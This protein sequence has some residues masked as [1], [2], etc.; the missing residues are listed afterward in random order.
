M[1]NAA[2]IK[3][4][5]IELRTVLD[6]TDEYSVFPPDTEGALDRTG[7]IYICAVQSHAFEIALDGPAFWEPRKARTQAKTALIARDQ[8]SLL[9]IVQ[10]C[11]ARWE[12]A[13]ASVETTV[14]GPDGEHHRRPYEKVWESPVNGS[15]FTSV[16]GLLA[17]AGSDLFDAVFDSAPGTALD[18]V[19]DLL[20]AAVRSGEQIV[21]ICAPNFHLPWRMLY[22]HPVENEKLAADGGN[23]RPEGFWGYR[24]VIEHFTKHTAEGDFLDNVSAVDGKLGFAAA[25]YSNLDA[26]LDVKCIARHHEFVARH[27]ADL[28]YVEWTEADK[29]KNGLKLDPFPYRV[30]YFLC[31]AEVAGDAGKPSLA[32]PHL[33]FPDGSIRTTDLTYVGKGINRAKPIVFLNAC[34][35]AQLGTFL[36]H[37]F[38]MA[39]EFIGKGALCLIG[40]EIEMPAV[41]AGEFGSRFFEHLFERREPAPRT[42]LVLRSLTQKMWAV[43]NPLGLAFGLYAGADCHVRWH[44]VSPQ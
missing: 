17:L 13:L 36:G 7:S 26:E 41:F 11:R 12:E 44:E 2:A 22:T 18:G 23:A 20:K 40:P 38:S 16:I 9:Q 1:N 3:R 14:S 19:A 35:A 6:R 39:A 8:N 28:N 15:E 24:H 4:T 29:V 5:P 43:R 25:L 37:D 31:H 10:D 27:T 32:V 42:G 33:R 21:T 30:I 34:R